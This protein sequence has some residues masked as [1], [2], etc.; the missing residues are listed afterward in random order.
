MHFAG[1]HCEDRRG[2][3]RRHRVQ[4]PHAASVK[5]LRLLID[6]KVGAAGADAASI[7]L[8]IGTNTNVSMSLKSKHKTWMFS[9]YFL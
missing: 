2:Q 5:D 1:I 8:R 9:F 7:C 4:Q 3:T 6:K